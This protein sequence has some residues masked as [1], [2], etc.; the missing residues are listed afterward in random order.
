MRDGGAPSFARPDGRRTR[1]PL[2]PGRSGQPAWRRLTT[3]ACCTGLVL[4]A[5]GWDWPA[6]KEPPS[7]PTG[8][9]RVAVAR[10]V[11]PEAVR[12]TLK[13]TGDTQAPAGEGQA[14]RGS[15]RVWVDADTDFLHNQIIEALVQSRAVDVVERTQLD[16]VLDEQQLVRDKVADPAEAARLG[17][18]LGAQY[19]V[20]GSLADV[21]EDRDTRPVPYTDRIEWTLRTRIKVEYRVVEVE[22][23]RVLAADS[24]EVDQ[25]SSGLGGDEEGDAAPR[26]REARARRMAGEL[27]GRVLD[28][29]APARL[30]RVDAQEV[31]LSR[32]GSLGVRPGMIYD[33]LGPVESVKD[34][35]GGQVI[36]QRQP[37]LGRIEVTGVTAISATARVVE[38]T[39]EWKVGST[40][41]LVPPAPRPAAPPKQD[42]LKG[43]W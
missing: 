8:K 9:P 21:S 32:G 36:G 25:A 15:S 33:V 10:L 14:G 4:V 1:D 3:F 18:V 16:R 39:G 37:R 5:A 30:L 35:D 24:A 27:A 43:R 26:I 40:C 20:V 13:A 42:P 11:I 12:L 19:F 34:P 29:V 31:E 22:S 17:K 6:A 38:K 23:S 28:V 7:A 2:G 41:R